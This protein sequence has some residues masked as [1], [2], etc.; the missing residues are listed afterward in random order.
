MFEQTLI[1]SGGA[2]ARGASLAASL[3]AQVAVVGVALLVPLVFTDKLPFVRM[4]ESLVAPPQPPPPPFVQIVASGRAPRAIPAQSN[5][6][7][8]VLPAHIPDRAET[9]IDEAPPAF[10]GSI[11]IEGGT[12][13]PDGVANGVLNGILSANRAVAPPPT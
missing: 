3:C 12:G 6:R 4:M 2:G 1:Q 7:T 11:G 5:G 9:I 13:S 10:A 8:L